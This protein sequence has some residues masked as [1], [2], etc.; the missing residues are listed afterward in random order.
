MQYITPILL[1]SLAKQ[2]EFDDE[3]DWNPNKAAGV[4]LM[5]M[6][7]CCENDIVEH[8]LPFVKV[9]FTFRIIEF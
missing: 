9:S 8:V 2:E 1:E 6:A 7:S 4:C 5:L 3:D